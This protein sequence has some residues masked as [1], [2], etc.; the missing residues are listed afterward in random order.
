MPSLSFNFVGVID[1]SDIVIL[2]GV[3][4]LIKIEV[5]TVFNIMV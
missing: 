5:S 4:V 2:R 3:V 1:F